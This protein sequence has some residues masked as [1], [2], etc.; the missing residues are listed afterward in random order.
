M[1]QDFN[2]P[3]P[4]IAE[5]TLALSGNPLVPTDKPSEASVLLARPQMTS[6]RAAHTATLLSNGTVFLAGGFTGFE[7]VLATAELFDPESQTFSSI[8]SMGESR[9]SHTATLLPNGLVLIA[10]GFNGDYL[11][12]AQLFDPAT[13]TFSPTGHMTVPRSGHTAVLLDIGFVLMAGGTSTGWVFLSSTVDI[14]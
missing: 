1:S 12:S 13:G 4:D 3:G 10:G 2:D 6:P 5:S 9:Q 11:A 14:S 8:A 7:Q